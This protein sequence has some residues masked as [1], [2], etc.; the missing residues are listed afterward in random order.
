MR[1]GK[2]S[3]VGAR[4]YLRIKADSSVASS[5]SSNRNLS[6]NV[7]TMRSAAVAAAD[8]VSTADEANERCSAQFM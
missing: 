4:L 3:S 5:S 2:S 1:S 7:G 8:D 6:L